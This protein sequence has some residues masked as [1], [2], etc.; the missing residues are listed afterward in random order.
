MYYNYS[1]EPVLMLLILVNLFYS[2][3]ALLPH[4]DLY[5]ITHN[6]IHNNN[7]CNIIINISLHKKEKKVKQINNSNKLLKSKKNIQKQNNETK[8]C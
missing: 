6:Y 2:L 8:N 5:Y 3:L 1:L 4:Y 7:N